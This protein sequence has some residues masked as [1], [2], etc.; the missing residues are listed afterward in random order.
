[1]CNRFGV[2]TG[3]C[4][5]CLQQGWHGLGAASHFSQWGRVVTPVPH[6]GGI[7]HEPLGFKPCSPLA[8]LFSLSCTSHSPNAAPGCWHIMA[9]HGTPQQPVHCPPGLFLQPGH[10][11]RRR[12]NNRQAWARCCCTLSRSPCLQLRCC[13]H[14]HR[15]GSRLGGR[16]R[17]SLR[18][19]SSW[20]ARVLPSQ[21]CELRDV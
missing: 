13:W 12:P 16:L 9:R 7:G 3:L 21:M 10:V 11:A 18:A 5:V 15:A 4:L 2:S 14:L 17:G 20:G 1:M 6:G 8:G 19:G